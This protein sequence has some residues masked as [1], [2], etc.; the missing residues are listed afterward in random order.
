MDFGIP[1]EFVRTVAARL[2]QSSITL[3]IDDYLYESSLRRMSEGLN[4]LPG[5]LNFFFF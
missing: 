2:H 4:L 1:T 3:P 5:Y